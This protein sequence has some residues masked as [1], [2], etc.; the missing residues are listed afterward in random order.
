MTAQTTPEHWRVI[1]GHHG[2]R[3]GVAAVAGDGALSGGST[4]GPGATFGHLAAK[5]AAQERV[6]DL[7]SV[8]DAAAV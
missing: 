3:N 7:S 4:S 1:D 5:P 2:A 6:R 8:R